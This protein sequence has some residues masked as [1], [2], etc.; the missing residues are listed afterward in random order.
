[1]TTVERT[2]VDGSGESAGGSAPA[3]A[4]DPLRWL[5]LALVP[6]P[7][8][9][10]LAEA[11]RSPRMNFNDYWAVLAKVANE[12]GSLRADV[13]LDLYNE[14]PITLAGP[15]FW[16]DAKFFSAY[17]W[18]LGV[19]NVVLVAVML[20]GLVRMLPP[21]LTGRTRLAVVVA[22]STLL[23]SSAALEYFGMGMSGLHWLVGLVP[24]VLAIGF[25]QRGQT[26]VAAVLAVVGCFGHGSAFP[27][28]AALAV[29]AWLRRDRL[30]Q[31]LLPIA[32]GVVTVVLWLLP[33]RPPEYPAPTL[34]GADSLLS[35]ALAMLGQVWAARD[36]EVAAVAGAVTVVFALTALVRA[37]LGDA[38][39]TDS[40][41]FGLAVHVVLVAGMVGASRARF[42]N[43][44][45][46]GPRYA[47]VAL[48]GAAALLVLLVVR[49]PVLARRHAVPIALV[50]G[51][52]AYA[53]GS[54]NAAAVRANYPKQPVLAVAMRVGALSVIESM[55]STPNVIPVLKSLRAYPFTE[56]FSLGC[57]PHELGSVIDMSQVGELPGPKGSAKTAGAVETG[58]VE[59]DAKVYG[60]AAVDGHAAD[61]V[62]VVDSGSE[63]VG[64]GAV[65]LPRK[66]VVDT[67]H[68][69]GRA[70]WQVVAEPGTQGG[71]VLVSSGGKLYRTTLVIDVE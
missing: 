1:M 51:V 26:A 54:A 55:N 22:L 32:L 52:T 69:T 39:V 11:V 45:A 41:W 44:E 23:F 7:A 67:I 30:W 4:R 31:V 37:R 47:M 18:V 42:G 33:S 25:A 27:V 16:L 15:L 58:P 3:P 63:V 50:F 59:G 34:L 48:L 6:V 36:V 68:A 8:L 57:G 56:D 9:I 71:V 2:P 49:G 19:G 14:H 70:G 29:V 66:D 61:C 53:V 46:L 20:A 12:D 35:T 28:W 5:L 64:G 62:L 38:P 24:A 10:A 21:A 40:G 43:G 17:N 65:G 60:W 13:L